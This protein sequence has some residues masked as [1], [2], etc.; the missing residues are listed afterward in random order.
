M[1]GVT[2]GVVGVFVLAIVQAVI[3][4]AQAPGGTSQQAAR[5]VWDGIYTEAQ[6]QRGR[7]FYAE[8]CASC[9]GTNLEGAEHRALK[10]DRFWATWQDTTVDRLLNH[11]SLNMPH[12]EDGSLKGT[13]GARVY[14]DIVA[15]ILSTNQFPAGT[16][17]LSESSVAG[18]RIIR[19]DGSGELPAGSLAHV[20]GCLEKGTG[21]NWKLIKGSR[22]ARVVEGQ[23]SDRSAPLGDREYALMFVLTPLDK[24]VG[25]RMS[26]RASLIGE[27]GAQ[28]LNVTTIESVSSTCQVGAYP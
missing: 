5:T 2:A 1:R 21:R 26:V 18:V 12:S 8:H 23:A 7:G 11:V 17:D 6:A 24:F 19:K 13:L 9:H 25:H 28:G 3:I 4:G 16:T 14:A 15:H 27:G 10:G 22:P 20:V